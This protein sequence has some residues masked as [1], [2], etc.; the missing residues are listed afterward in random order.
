MH[1]IFKIKNTLNLDKADLINPLFKDTTK[2]PDY[3]KKFKYLIETI[4]YKIKKH[5]KFIMIRVND[6]ELHFLNNNPI[7]NILR[8]HYSKMPNKEDLKNLV[9]DL[10]YADILFTQSRINEIKIFSRLLPN[11]H[12]ENVELMYALFSSRELFKLIRNEKIGIIGSEKKIKIIKRLMDYQEYKQ[13]LGLE[14]INDFFSIPDEKF[15]DQA[16]RYK[17]KLAKYLDETSSNVFLIGAGIGKLELLKEFNKKENGVFIDVGCG[18]TAMAGIV[19]IKRPYFGNWT[20]FKLSDINYKKLDLVD[21]KYGEKF[22]E[23]Y[24]N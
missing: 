23:I 1:D 3:Q 6:G 15:G 4:E 10:D 16:H 17:E 14:S 8:R 22:N 18:I 13:Y 21:Y 2:Y 12:P 7:G 19:N 9:K 24:L 20:N 11:R 5:E